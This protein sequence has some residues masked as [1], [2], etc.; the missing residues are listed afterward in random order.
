[1]TVQPH[2]IVIM[3]LSLVLTAAGMY[4][5]IYLAPRR[6]NREWNSARQRKELLDRTRWVVAHDRNRGFW[7]R[8]GVVR[9]RHLMDPARP[10]GPVIATLKDRLRWRYA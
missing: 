8:T 6:W 3:G 9:R 2:E 7:E 1:M 5:T 4:W 10:D